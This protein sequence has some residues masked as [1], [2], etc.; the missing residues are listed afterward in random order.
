MQPLA[1]NPERRAKARLTHV[2]PITI[3]DIRTGATYTARMFNYSETGI[4]F[5]C[6]GML[7]PG[8]AVYIGIRRTPYERSPSDYNCYRGVITWR[9][10]LPEDSH[11]YYGY[12]LQFA[13]GHESIEDC[14]ND[15]KPV[16]NK[17]KHPRKPLKK[18]IRFSDEKQVFRGWTGD[19]SPSGV[20]VNSNHG[21]RIG[22]M[23]TLAIPDK[24]GKDVLIR[25]QVVW[26]SEKGFGV[27]F[28]KKI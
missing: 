26:S 16:E 24:D 19:I 21:F 5:E 17:R 1:K 2:A 4:Y 12:G 6:D 14:Q 3:K 28:I 7:N 20:F 8:T 23:V 15:R 27:K 13:S 10:K 9:G 11:F 22:Q 18:P 25:G